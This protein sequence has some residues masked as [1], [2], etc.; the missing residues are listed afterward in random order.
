[1]CNLSADT[2][3]E[4]AAKHSNIIGL[5][6]SID[7]ISHTRDIINKVKA[8]HKEFLVF[9]GLDEYLLMNLLNGGSGVVG[10]LSNFVPEILVACHQAYMARDYDQVKKLYTS[11]SSL[12]E[13]Y[14]I[15]ELLIPVLKQAV[16]CKIKEINP[17]CR[18]PMGSLESDKALYV[19]KLLETNNVI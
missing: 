19:R 13:L 17:I 2:V 14:S 8:V 1:M 18:Q 4:L 3:S 5:K 6:D 11:V 10:D 12:S 7:S 9:S 16:A 15:S